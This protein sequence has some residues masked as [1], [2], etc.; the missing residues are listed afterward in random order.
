MRHLHDFAAV[1]RWMDVRP[2]ACA[3]HLDR[4]GLA[5]AARY[6]LTLALEVDPDAFAR[7]VLRSLPRD[8]R[9]RVLARVADAVLSRVEPGNQLAIPFVHSLNRSVV[10]G[11]RS[12]YAHVTAPKG[13]DRSRDG[14]WRP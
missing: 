6:A 11:A 4:M 5:R 12:F 1:G 13:D 3:D 10:Q 8:R 7:D 14:W 9:G 2:D